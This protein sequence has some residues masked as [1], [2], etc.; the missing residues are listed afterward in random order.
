MKITPMVIQE[1]GSG[2]VLS[3]FY[4]NDESFQKMKET[5]K[6]WRYS[7]SKKQVIMKGDTSG[8][9]QVVKKIEWDC[10]NDAI[11]VTVEQTGTGACHNGTWSCFPQGKGNSRTRAKNGFEAKGALEELEL[12]IK[13]RK[14]SPKSGSY[15]SQIIGSREKI[16]EKLR[17]ESE[18]F[19][20]A[21]NEKDEREVVWEAADM[22]YFMLVALANR[23]IP[24]ELVFAE[25]RRRRK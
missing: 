8:N 5:G 18:E 21:F 12:V 24:L 10:D 6:V 17:E 22:L 14:A 20:E 16:T 19:V 2:Q 3:L 23:G 13:E 7:R 15:T 4:A 1:E 9:V 25:L 11:L